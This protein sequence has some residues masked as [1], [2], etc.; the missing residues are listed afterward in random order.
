MTDNVVQF[1]GA[2][3]VDLSAGAVL[4]MAMEE[5]LDMVVVMGWDKD[6]NE[7]L[8]STTSDARTIIFLADRVKWKMNVQIDAN[9]VD[10]HNGKP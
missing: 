9:I 4:K 8:A 3:T 7:Y 6:G 2:T 1:P 10:Q 5:K